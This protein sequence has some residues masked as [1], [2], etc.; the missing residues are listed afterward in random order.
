MIEPVEPRRLLAA[1]AVLVGTELRVAVTSS[2]DTTINVTHADGRISVH[3]RDEGALR[4][5]YIGA[6]KAIDTIR[7]RGSA[8][9]DRITLGEGIRATTVDAGAGRDVIVGNSGAN[10]IHG[11]DGNDQVYAGGGDDVIFGENGRDTLFGGTGNDRLY[12]GSDIDHLFG[13]A[14]DDR[15]EGGVS[16]HADYLDGGLGVDRLIGAQG[17]DYNKFDPNDRYTDIDLDQDLPPNKQGG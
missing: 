4:R 11:G 5:V 9:S 8:M 3:V 1:S 14:G 12:G 13:E 17:S 7:V 2:V 15:L 16:K 10:T 6:R